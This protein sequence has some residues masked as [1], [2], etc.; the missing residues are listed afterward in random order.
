MNDS[1][2]LT[3]VTY[4][5]YE[6]IVLSDHA[7]LR[8]QLNFPCRYSARTW[9]MDNGLLASET[10]VEF[11]RSQIALYMQTN[12]TP[13]VSKSILWEALK[14]F[15]R[16]QIISYSAQLVKTKNERGRNITGQLVELDKRYAV[17]PTPDLLV[18]RTSLQTEFNLLS[19]A[20][21]TKLINR[22]R[23]KYYE[24]GEGIG[25]QLAHQIRISEA[26][27]YITEIRTGSGNT[28][29]DQLEI[30]QEFKQF[31]SKLYTTETA[32]NSVTIQEFFDSLEI[33][34]ICQEDRCLLEE[35]ITLEEVTSAVRSLQSSKAPGPDG[36]TTEFYK[37]FVTEVAPLLL[38]VFNESFE[39]GSLPTTFYQATISLIH[40]K[41]KDP[42]DAASYRPVS[43][44]NVDT[45]ILAKILAIRLENV[46]PT[47]IH[48]D[49]TGF[50]KN[51]QLSH[52]IRRLFNIIYTSNTN[53]LSEILLSLDAEKAFDRVEW[54][55]LFS[56]LSR[57]G[58]G[59]RYI[60]W[61]RLLYASPMASV[62]TN[63]IR[64]EYFR[65]TRSTRQG[66][67]LSPLLFA[68]A[69]E[70]LAVSL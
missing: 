27:R 8:L 59:P 40:K 4:L 42:L 54:G 57:F 2:L 61:I 17:S 55:Y 13:D 37:T 34:S 16:G 63:K 64:S 3:I 62:Q 69:I 36:Y 56:A 23:H 39:T 52:N 50:I 58:F 6:A 31:Y 9:R 11:I 26:S 49:Q 30:N 38:R 24:H 70:P 28:T 47:I 12:E 46:L 14:A 5:D 51:R 10:H 1:K 19:T 32:A 29:K 22:S 65:L 21:T 60:S 41:G 35:P 15:V 53:S 66:C 48:E 7:P 44:L 33:P 68:L 18:R 20:E 67:P 43:L 25:R 45:K